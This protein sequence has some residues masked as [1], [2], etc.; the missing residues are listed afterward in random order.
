MW[1]KSWRFLFFSAGVLILVGGPQHPKGD[2]A[3]MLA[4]SAW[5]PAHSYLLAG[6]VAM[7][8][9]LVLSARNP[10][11]ARMRLWL[12]L[13]IAGTVLQC[14]EMA[15]HLAAK[16]DVENLVAGRPTPVLTT[17]LFLAVCV[18]PIFAATVIGLIIAGAREHKLGSWWIAW[19]GIIGTA[20]HGLSAPLVVAVKW[21]PAGILFPFLMGLALWLVL[22]S[23]WPVRAGEDLRHTASA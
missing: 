21:G 11:S 2:M 5:V 23:V 1:G 22:A 8:L 20:G 3:Q 19:L 17:H 15:L 4:D 10:L 14:I 6:F 13:A 12:R 7:L 16:V 18:Y 9:G